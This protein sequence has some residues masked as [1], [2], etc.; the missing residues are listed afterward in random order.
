M[1][2]ASVGFNEYHAAVAD[3]RHRDPHLR[4]RK[5]VAVAVA[6]RVSLHGAGRVGPASGFGQREHT[7]L[8]PG[9]EVGNE[10]LHL[11]VA[12]PIENCE[13]AGHRLHIHRVSEFGAGSRQ[14]LGDDGDRL[15]AH[16]AAA[17]RFRK[18]R[19]EQASGAHLLD[20]LMGEALVAFVGADRRFDLGRDKTRDGVT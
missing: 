4:T 15:E 20:D 16:L 17:Q 9:D 3:I 2:G 5:N 8:A 7:E 1:A 13:R 14:F 19:T 6:N 10:A 11:F 18:R 12:A